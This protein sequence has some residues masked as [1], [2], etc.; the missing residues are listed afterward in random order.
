MDWIEI[1]GIVASVFVLVSFVF[2]NQ[3]VIRSINVIGSIIF[4]VYGVLIHSLSIWLLNG[5][6]VLVHCYYII[7]YVVEMKNNSHDKMIESK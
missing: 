3:I 4:V 7:K 2:K 5:I 1:I 6:L